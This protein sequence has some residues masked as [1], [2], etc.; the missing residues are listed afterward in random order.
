MKKYHTTLDDLYKTTTEL[1]YPVDDAVGIQDGST[2]II[3]L[4][5]AR[6]IELQ[7]TDNGDLY[8]SDVV[9]VATSFLHT[10]YSPGSIV[11]LRVE[12]NV[13]E[14]SIKV[15]EILTRSDKTKANSYSACVDMLNTLR[16]TPDPLDRRRS[17]A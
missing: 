6:S 3:K 9:V 12:R 17:L 2:D 15:V 13:V 5:D 4:K 11:E 14:N 7:L 8:S 1:N 10:L 16:E